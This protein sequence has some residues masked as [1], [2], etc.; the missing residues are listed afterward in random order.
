MRGEESLATRGFQGRPRIDND[1]VP[2]GQHVVTDFPVLTA[3][4]TED[5]DRDGWQLRITD[6]FVTK[7][8]NWQQ[9][10][11]LSIETITVDIHC[12]THWSKLDTTWGGV[13]IPTLFDDAGVGDFDYAIIT[14]YGGYTT[15]LPLAD[16]ADYDAMIATTFDGEPI[17]A[18]HGGPVRLVVPHLYFWKSAKWLQEIRLSDDDEPGFWEVSGYHNYGDPWREQRYFSD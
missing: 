12:V 15:N 5:I 8:Y 1:R 14:S 2:P 9:L 16:L 3:G 17:D 13:T 7:T 4:G 6:G 10:H 18:E 11:A